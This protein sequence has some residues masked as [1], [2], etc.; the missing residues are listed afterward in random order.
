[1]T[2]MMRS[3]CLFGF[4]G[5]S[6]AVRVQ[7]LEMDT[8]GL[9]ATS[10]R[11]DVRTVRDLYDNIVRLQL[12]Q[13]DSDLITTRKELFCM[14]TKLENKNKSIT[15]QWDTLL[16]DRSPANAEFTKSAS[17]LLFLFFVLLLVLFLVQLTC[18]G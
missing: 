2:F 18:F 16:T 11:G 10:R 6:Q 1:M 12:K 9:C 14:K 4:A 5:L 15:E 8:K 7:R 3:F 13:F 17:L